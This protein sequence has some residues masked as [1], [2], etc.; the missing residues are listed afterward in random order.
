MDIGVVSY[1]TPV[2]VVQFMLV[3]IGEVTNSAVTPKC[4]ESVVQL[5]VVRVETGGVI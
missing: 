3:D 1:D 5:V 4:G 2:S